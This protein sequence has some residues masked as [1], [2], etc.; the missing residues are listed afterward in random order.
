MQKTF[1]LYNILEKLEVPISYRHYG[2]LS[3]LPVELK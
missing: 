3:Q 1:N 2:L